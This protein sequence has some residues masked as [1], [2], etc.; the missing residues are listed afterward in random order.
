MVSG[1]EKMVELQKAVIQCFTLTNISAV[2]RNSF[3]E[4]KQHRNDDHWALSGTVLWQR[5]CQAACCRPNVP[6]RG[7]FHLPLSS[8]F[9]YT[10][11]NLIYPNLRL[12]PDCFRWH[13]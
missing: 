2:Q 12:S 6:Q 7:C 3:T 5:S 1:P 13:I 8:A 11:H 4:S 9:F 10:R